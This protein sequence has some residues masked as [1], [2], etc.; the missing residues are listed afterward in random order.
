MLYV[1]YIF[2]FVCFQ[3]KLPPLLLM[4]LVFFYLTSYVMWWNGSL[5]INVGCM[6]CYLG[7]QLTDVTYTTCSWEVCS[8]SLYIPTPCV[9]WPR[10]GCFTCLCISNQLSGISLDSAYHDLTR[11]CAIH[12]TLEHMS[13]VW[14]SLFA[15]YA[16]TH[17]TIVS[18]P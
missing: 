6:C 1:C 18:I 2:L 4:P 11:H 9:R 13:V 12:H 14:R 5:C 15:I 7:H 17:H 16:F 8:A 10:I 3:P